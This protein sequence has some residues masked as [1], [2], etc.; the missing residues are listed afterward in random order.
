MRR[1]FAVVLLTL[2]LTLAV[3]SLAVAG[4]G[5]P[6]GGCPDGFTLHMVMDHT[7]PDGGKHHHA[8]TDNDRNGD[9]WICGKHVSTSE[10]VHVHI[11]NN[12]PLP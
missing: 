1:I 10:N 3:V 4:G 11:D 12:T 8:G 6:Q 9:G 5:Q 2:L 7:H